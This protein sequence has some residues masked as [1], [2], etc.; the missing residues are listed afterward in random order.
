MFLSKLSKLLKKEL[1]FV[2]STSKVMSDNNNK[3]FESVEKGEDKPEWYEAHK[4]AIQVT[5]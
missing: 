2:Y 3:N 5:I 1:S 4:I